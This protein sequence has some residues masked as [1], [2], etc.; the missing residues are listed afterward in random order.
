MINILV[1]GGS[2]RLAEIKKVKINET[3]KIFIRP[4]N[5]KKLFLFKFK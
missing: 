2:S 5:L 4:K 1:I 3:I